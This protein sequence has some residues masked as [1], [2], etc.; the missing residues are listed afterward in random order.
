M[1]IF[2]FES[3]A[4][5]QRRRIHEFG[6]RIGQEAAKN[7]KYDPEVILL[8]WNSLKVRVRRIRKHRE[9]LNRAMAG[10]GVS[11]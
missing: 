1:P 8:L 2:N 7:S 4:E 10:G 11:A 9:N 5:R 3:K 6:T